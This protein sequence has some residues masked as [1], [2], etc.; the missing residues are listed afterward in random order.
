MDSSSRYI[1]VLGIKS[2]NVS[3]YRAVNQYI[4]SNITEYNIYYFYKPDQSF[5]YCLGMLQDRSAGRLKG[6]TDPTT[7]DPEN[8]HSAIPYSLQAPWSTAEVDPAA[9]TN[10]N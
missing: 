6:N 5:L 4:V 1:E 9:E 7:K 10:Y 2:T 3:I 8:V